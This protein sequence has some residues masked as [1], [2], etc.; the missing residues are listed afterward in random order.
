M[1][2]EKRLWLAVLEK[3][4]DDAR[5]LLRRVVQAEFRGAP[6][7]WKNPL[8][9]QDVWN[10][11]NWFRKESQEVGGFGFICDVLDMDPDS[12]RHRVNTLYFEPLEATRV[13]TKTA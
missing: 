1:I 10:L 7:L 11:K 13:Y 8:F 12:A 6:S 4:V 9:Y 2:Q 5:L 3:A